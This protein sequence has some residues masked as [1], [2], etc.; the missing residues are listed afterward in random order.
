MEMDADQLEF[1]D[2]LAVDAVLAADSSRVALRGA[3]EPRPILD[4]RQDLTN[5]EMAALKQVRV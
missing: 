5:A 1:D 3:D 2:W 4:R